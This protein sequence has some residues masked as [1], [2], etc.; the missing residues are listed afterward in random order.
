MINQITSDA[1]KRPNTT[2]R[3][4]RADVSTAAPKTSSS[5]ATSFSAE[6]S[7]GIVNDKII[8]AIDKE[9]SKTNET[10]VRELDAKNFTPESVAKGILQFVQNAISRAKA[11]GES[12]DK[13][14][15]QARQGIDKGFDE[16]KNILVGLNALSGQIAEGVQ[17]TYN[18]I[19]HGLSK[20]EAG[21]PLSS[22]ETDTTQQQIISNAQ[23][24]ELNI[25][26]R[27]GDNVQI[28]IS[29]N[30][31]LKEYS[32]LLIKS[33]ENT[34]ISNVE[35]SNSNN[36]QIRVAG[37]LDKTEISAIENLLSDVKTI[38]DKFF[39][40]GS[41]IAFEAGLNLGFN[42]T[43][44]ASFA[45]SLNESQTQQASKTYREV[46]NFGESATASPSQLES[47]LKP[48][49]E[50][51]TELKDT[52]Q[53]DSQSS[54]FDSSANTVGNLFSYFSR[55]NPDNTQNIQNLESLSNSTL[56]AISQQL[57][58]AAQ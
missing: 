41:N 46:S 35:T 6:S 44:I 33:G 42:T 28:N 31:T 13:L 36:I 43:Q 37:N 25:K 45:L 15:S 11:R 34:S 24:F 19:N 18:L 5:S 7:L 20:L 10:S 14:L 16:A 4:T 17:K 55:N 30:Q 57:I 1:L 26:T 32:A 40:E 49:H 58:S 38:S 50:F 39:N 54:T 29:Q 3:P 52:L 2:T 21:Q 53:N 51:M 22:L 23:S 8:D 12:T 9:L 47:L 56:E 48:A 27:D